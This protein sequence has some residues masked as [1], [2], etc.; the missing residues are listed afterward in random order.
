MQ[1]AEGDV[2]LAIATGSKLARM[3]GLGSMARHEGAEG[4]GLGKL[5]L[6]VPVWQ[7]NRSHGE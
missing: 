3:S 2:P 7:E 4:D 6:G 1:L 5:G